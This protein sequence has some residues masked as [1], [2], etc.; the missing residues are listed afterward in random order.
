MSRAIERDNKLHILG[1]YMNPMV[2]A[3]HNTTT[4]GLFMRPTTCHIQNLFMV[5]DQMIP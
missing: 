2:P 5:V 1:L 3:E 4:L